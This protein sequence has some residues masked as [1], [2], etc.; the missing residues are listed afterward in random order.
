MSVRV[1]WPERLRDAEP[2]G[3]ILRLWVRS[4]RAEPAARE[5]ARRAFEAAWEE[6]RQAAMAGRWS[7]VRYWLGRG[8]VVDERGVPTPAPDEPDPREQF[9]KDFR[10]VHTGVARQQLP[11]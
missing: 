11:T 1:V 10:R 8:A 6:C 2:D 7:E 9:A 5:E 4:D 3:A